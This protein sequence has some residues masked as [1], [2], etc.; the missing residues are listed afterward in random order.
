M[1]SA[2]S[3][4]EFGG[5]QLVLRCSFVHVHVTMLIDLILDFS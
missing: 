3:L 2:D 5:G 1:D 4:E